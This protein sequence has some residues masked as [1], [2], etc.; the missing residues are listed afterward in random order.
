MM[1]ALRHFEHADIEEGKILLNGNLPVILKN[2]FLIR[3]DYFVL[4]LTNLTIV[5][6]AGPVPKPHNINVE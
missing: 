2:Y 1:A 3:K 4:S 6:E 5:S